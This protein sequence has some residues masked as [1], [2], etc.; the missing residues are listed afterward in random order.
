MQLLIIEI[1][2]TC[3]QL[4]YLYII[5]IE[6]E[7]E[8]DIEREKSS[9]FHLRKATCSTKAIIGM[10]VIASHSKYVQ[11]KMLFRNLDF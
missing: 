11:R 8:W 6:R 10:F 1:I 9:S 2:Y 5:E 3:V 7:R 4:I